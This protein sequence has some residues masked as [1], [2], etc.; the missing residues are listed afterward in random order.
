M[1]QVYFLLVFHAAMRAASDQIHH[2]REP[3][4]YID[5]YTT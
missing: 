3:Q 5:T 4:Q 1:Y 2:V